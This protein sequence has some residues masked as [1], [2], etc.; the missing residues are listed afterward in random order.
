MSLP[1]RRHFPVPQGMESKLQ[2]IDGGI[3][4]SIQ[5][6]ATFANVS[7]GRECFHK[8]LYFLATIALTVARNHAY[9]EL[10]HKTHMVQA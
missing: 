10:G 9:Y 2:D 3:V 8:L 7:S 1:Q 6:T 4:V 5:F